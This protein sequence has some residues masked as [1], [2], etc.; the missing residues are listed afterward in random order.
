MVDFPCNDHSLPKGTEKLKFGKACFYHHE[1]RVWFID[2]R[3][4]KQSLDRELGK[5]LVQTYHEGEGERLTI[6][7]REGDKESA[8]VTVSRSFYIK[9]PLPHSV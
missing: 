9:P 4:V 5:R 6:G 1:D 2:H 3:G 7:R 8:N